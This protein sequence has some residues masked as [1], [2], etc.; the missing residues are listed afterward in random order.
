MIRNLRFVGLVALVMAVGAVISGPTQLRIA[1]A[2]PSAS[3]IVDKVQQYYAGIQHV[4]AQFRQEVTN[5]M[6]GQTKT[7]DGT[8]WI[9]KPGKMRWDYAENRKGVSM[10]KKSFISNGT[11]LWVVEH[12]NKQIIKKSLQQDLMPVAVSFLYGKGDL[13][14]EFTAEIDTKSKLGGGNDVVLKLTPKKPS[15]QYKNLYLS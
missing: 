4:Q 5:D 9:M 14:T 12:D 8:M 13:K 7:S 3:E 6:L 10:V 15:T 11:Q 1:Y 2:A